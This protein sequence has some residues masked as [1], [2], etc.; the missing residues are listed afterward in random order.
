[1]LSHVPSRGP[2][3]V[4]SG[5]ASLAAAALAVL[6]TAGLGAFRIGAFPTAVPGA[7]S[8]SPLARIGLAAALGV[9]IVAVNAGLYFALEN[10]WRPA[11]AWAGFSRFLLAGIVTTLLT[12][13]AVG[14]GFAVLGAAPLLLTVPAGLLAAQ[15]ARAAIVVRDYPW[16]VGEKWGS[17]WALAGG[18]ALVAAAASYRYPERL[19]LLAVVLVAALLLVTHR[20][21]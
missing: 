10:V 4:I 18:L 17:A 8:L 20:L 13:A 3:I 16:T 11:N 1:M 15:V 12:A 21:K 5:L 7:V 2:R 14:A 6:A 19:A 9:A